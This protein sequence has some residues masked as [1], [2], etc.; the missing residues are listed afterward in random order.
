MTKCY[1]CQ[2]RGWVP[3]GQIDDGRMTGRESCPICGGSGE[4]SDADLV[5]EVRRVLGDVP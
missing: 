4:L 2:G 5:R 1:R 3:D